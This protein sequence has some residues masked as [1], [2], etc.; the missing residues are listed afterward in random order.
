MG[1]GVGAPTHSN[2][3]K[4]ASMTIYS[5]YK[6]T[7]KINGK[8]YIGFDSHWPKRIKQHKFSSK[9]D[10]QIFYDA[11]RKYG[12]DN[13]EWQVLYQSKDKDYIWKVMENYFIVEYRTFVGFD[14][15]NGYN[16]TLGGDGRNGYHHSDNAKKKLSELSKGRIFSEETRKKISKALK[17]RTGSFKGKTFSEEHKNKISLAR[18]GKKHTEETKKKIGDINRGNTYALG[19]IRTKKCCP[20]CNKLA[21]PGNYNRWHGNKCKSVVSVQQ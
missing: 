9:K 8:S 4:D 10:R 16:M 5:I 21:D 11:I 15:C 18:I 2:I 12:W 19:I 13:F 7:N 1:H 6:A 17:G 3:S 20:H 14:D